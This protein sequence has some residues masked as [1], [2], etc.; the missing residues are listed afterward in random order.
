MTFELLLYSLFP[1][2]LLVFL[3]EISTHYKT[4]FLLLAALLLSAAF[5]ARWDWPGSS[6]CWSMWR[7]GSSPST[8]PIITGTWS[9]NCT[10]PRTVCRM[11][12]TVPCCLAARR[13]PGSCFSGCKR[14]PA[15]AREELL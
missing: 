7:P 4:P 8:P 15:Q 1:F 6:C 3:D 2:F 12:M 13:L 9:V 10:F 5:P 11:L 14:Q